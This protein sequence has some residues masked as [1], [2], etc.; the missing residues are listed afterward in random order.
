MSEPNSRRVALVTGGARGIGAAVVRELCAAGAAVVIADLLDAEGEALAG[1]LGE[2]EAF[3]HLDVTEPDGWAAAVAVAEQ[4]FGP[5][6]ILVNNAGILA[7]GGVGQVSRETFRHVLDVNLVGQ[8]NG[9]QAA[10]PSLRRGQDPIVVNVSSTAGLIGYAGIAA[11]VAS[12]WGV[13]GL[14][15][16]AALDL[17]PDGIR[18][19]SVHPGPIATPMTAGMDEETVQ[20]QPIARFGRPHEVATLVRYLAYEATFA[21]GGEYLVDGGAVAGTVLPLPE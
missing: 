16:A 3:V 5:L 14:T 18:V 19:V 1:E 21:T 13:R 8:L 7:Y 20:A 6:S 17:A 4:R 12:K 10:L 2:C 11:Y 9:I 15:K